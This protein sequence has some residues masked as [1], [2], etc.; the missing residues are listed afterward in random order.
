MDR[1]SSSTGRWE[2]IDFELEIREGSRRRYPVSVR[3]PA[4]E[5]QEQMRFPFDEWELENRLLALE[6]TLL[7]SGGAR[8]RIPSEE[9]QPIQEFG[10]SLLEALLVGEVR[11]RYAMSLLEARRQNKGLRLK[12]HVQPPELARLPWEFLYD[13]ERDEYLSL[14]DK[15]PLVRYPNLPQPVE[16]LPISPT[17]RILGMVASPFLLTEL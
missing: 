5:A 6:N 16:R 4:G 2:Y 15:T 3:S 9:E 8:R 13:P 12:L 10:Q 1:G 7:R 11:T 17:M 14:S